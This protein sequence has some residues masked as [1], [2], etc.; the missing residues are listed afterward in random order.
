M[1]SFL[2]CYW[3]AADTP[4]SYRHETRMTANYT[5]SVWPV[6][7]PRRRAAR[8][9]MWAGWRL[10]VYILLP[11][12]AWRR[13][14]RP[15]TEGVNVK[16]F[17]HRFDSNDWT[18][19]LNSI[20]RM[21][22]KAWNV[23]QTFD[24]ASPLIKYWLVQSVQGHNCCTYMSLLHVCSCGSMTSNTSADLDVPHFTSCLGEA[25]PPRPHHVHFLS[26]LRAKG[27]LSGDSSRRLGLRLIV[28]TAHMVYALCAEMW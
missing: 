7:A 21:C 15:A 12:L 9:A 27:R 1:Y 6:L 10:S 11:V 8:G 4:P 5:D 14:G 17:I 24:S 13:Q 25:T 28:S 3:P 26:A 16:G 18:A 22:F 20:T 2:L 23:G 19:V